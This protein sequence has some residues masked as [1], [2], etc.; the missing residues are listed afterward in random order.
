MS[1]QLFSAS[2]FKLG[3]FTLT[4]VSFENNLLATPVS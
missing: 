1:A 2:K 3:H 4:T